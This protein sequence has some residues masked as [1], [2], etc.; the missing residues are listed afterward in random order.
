[1]HLHR[2][3]VPLMNTTMVVHDGDHYRTKYDEA[4][5]VLDQKRFFL[6]VVRSLLTQEILHISV[7]GQ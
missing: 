3:Q 4:R 2:R 7:K 5:L 6:T 1:M